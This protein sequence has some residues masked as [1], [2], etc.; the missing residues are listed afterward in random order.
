MLI[1][2]TQR[3]LCKEDFL[4]RIHQLV[5]TRPYAVMLREKDLDLPAYERLARKVKEICDR[6]GVLLI[7]HRRTAVAEQLKLTHLQLSMPDLRVYKKG[8]HALLVGA[9]VHSVEE[10]EEAQALGAAYI[11]AG[12]IYATDCKKDL[13]SKG[14][15]YLRQVCQAVTLPVFAIGGVTGN[16]AKEILESG[17]K[18]FCVMSEAMTCQDPEK[19]V[20]TFTEVKFLGSQVT[21]L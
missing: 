7:I 1:C 12:H 9:S 8:D 17:A 13:P 6:H 18:G 15:S 20:R 2:V 3:K 16:N 10:A 19:L 21:V 4:Q 11:V 5:Q 14:L